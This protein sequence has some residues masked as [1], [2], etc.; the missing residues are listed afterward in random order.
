MSQR[1]PVRRPAPGEDLSQVLMQDAAWLRRLARRLAADGPRAEDAVQA[2]LVSAWSTGQRR[3]SRGW[4]A[5]TLRNALRSEARGEARRR[6]R[7]Q[8][9]AVPERQAD[10]SATLE[11]LE[12]QQRVVAAVQGLDEPY[13][14]TIVLR[15]LDGLSPRAI[16]ARTDTPVKTVHTRVERGLAKLRGT[17]DRAVGNDPEALDWRAALLALPGV[18][19]GTT[20]VLTGVTAM[21]TLFKATTATAGVALL[22]G[23]VYVLGPEADSGAVPAVEAHPAASEVEVAA[24]VPASAPQGAE[25]AAVTE[26]PEVTAPAAAAPVERLTSA[27]VVD[28][29]G[30]AVPGVRVVLQR[31]HESREAESGPDGA[32]ALILPLPAEA[33]PARALDW[34]TV[35]D[36][37]WLGLVQVEGP[38]RDAE[39]VVAPRVDVAGIVVDEDGAPLE[40]ASVRLDF[41]TVLELSL[42]GERRVLPEHSRRATSAADG[43]FQLESATAVEG[44]YVQVRLAGY[45]GARER[46]AVPSPAPLEIVLS[47]STAGERSVSGRVLTNDGHPVAGALVAARGDAAHSDE[48]GWFDVPVPELEELHLAAGQTTVDLWA[49]QPGSLPAR[50]PLDL[51]APLPDFVELRLG[52]EPLTISG[53]VVDPAGDPIGGAPVWI[54]D[55]EEFGV[56]P[57]DAGGLTFLMHRSVE[58]LLTE[59]GEARQGVTVRSDDEGRFALTGLL[60]R[61]YVVAALDERTLAVLPGLEVPGG[62][63]G[64]TLVVAPQRPLTAVAGRVVSGAGAPLAG[65]RVRAMSNVHQRGLLTSH[66]VPEVV[67]DEAGRFRFQGLSADGLVLQVVGEGIASDAQR[68]ID[69]AEDLLD[70]VL[71]APFAARLKLRSDDPRFA[72]GTVSLEDADGKA[73]FVTQELSGVRLGAAAF[74]LIEGRSGVLHTD[75]R[76]RTIV[77]RSPALDEPLRLPLRLEPG[78]LLELEVP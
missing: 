62:T 29:E 64:L 54:S 68:R 75:D 20:S 42:Q 58:E 78:T 30:R 77:L 50:H 46:V 63:Q 70:L 51:A 59:D 66:G 13:R 72:S 14:T 32:V 15:F 52:P 43:T 11:R 3:P 22:A 26:E 74:Q 67:S 57:E 40:G 39:L 73:L 25:R 19:A 34:L 48:E 6:A 55:L 31:G 36:P 18:S 23:A 4:L 7:E 61:E 27:R 9:V 65:Q 37:D 17:L 35:D 71:V 33:D 2:T 16:A 47:R 69:P 44:L 38:A 28:V 5:T 53:R 21:G 60:D 45:A 24:A 76:V 1:D 49:V 12:L 56:V 41:P 8:A 10:D